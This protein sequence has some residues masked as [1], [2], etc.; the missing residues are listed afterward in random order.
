[1]TNFVSP[2]LLLIVKVAKAPL[3]AASVVKPVIQAEA[4][5]RSIPPVIIPEPVQTK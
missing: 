2:A 3:A 5:A 1:M 4:E